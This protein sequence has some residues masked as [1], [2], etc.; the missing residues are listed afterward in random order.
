VVLSQQELKELKIFIE[1]APII[2]QMENISS[3]T[4]MF[5]HVWITL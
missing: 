1:F 4:L 2:K 5:K 3:I